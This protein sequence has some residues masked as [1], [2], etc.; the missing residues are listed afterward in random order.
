MVSAPTGGAEGTNLEMKVTLLAHTPG[1]QMLAAVAAR[2]CYSST[3]PS[4]IN[5]SNTQAGG[6]LDKVIGSGHL[7]VTRHCTFSFS[8]EGV[9]RALSHQLVRHTV[10]AE[11]SQQ[12][13]RYVV[14][15]EISNNCIIPQSIE[16]DPLALPTYLT[17]L[18]EI[19]GAYMQMIDRGIPAEDARMI[20]PNAMRTNIVVTM[21]V[22][23][24]LNFLSKRCCLRAQ[25]EIRALA[26][27]LL[28]IVKPIAP[29]FFSKAGKPCLFGECPEGKLSCG[30]NGGNNGE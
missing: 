1:P 21:S 7:S 29:N 18:D 8:V 26:D 24:L 28:E 19:E 13:Q 9:S 14:A 27:M 12:S 3:P 11:F 20:L 15:D 2:T 6:L 5:L 25:W 16:D 17:A 22:E 30:Y 4:E 10:G 23:A